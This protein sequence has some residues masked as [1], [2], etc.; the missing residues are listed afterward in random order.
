[1][2][3]LTSGGLTISRSWLPPWAS[4]LA[5]GAILVALVAQLGAQPFIEALDSVNVAA[6]LAAGAITAG[7]TWACARRWRLLAD[8]LGVGVSPMAAY[9][10]CYRAQFL[11]ATLPSG[12]VGEVDRALW[13]GRSSKSLSKGIRSVLWDRV[14]GQAVLFGLTMLAIPL[15]A[16][17]LRTW[18][19]WLLAAAVVVAFVAHRANWAFARALRDEARDVPGA[20]GVWS[21]VLL[22]STL[23]IAGHVTVFI[24]AARS[25]GVAA[26]TLELATLGLVVLQFSSIPLAVAGWGPREGGSALVF[27][28]AGLDASTGLAVSVTYGV[29]A[30][31]ATLPGVLALGRRRGAGPTGDSEGGTSWAI[32][33]TRS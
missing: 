22:L 13:H 11:N 31:L 12:V 21:R 18:L 10:A 8:R 29:L 33:P 15:L 32:V 1:M 4:V 9:R 30:T 20:P 6:I 26:S 16:P 5:G 14:S 28:A 23:A 25:V 7:T 27:A 2:G 3:H 17:S 24:V 19:L